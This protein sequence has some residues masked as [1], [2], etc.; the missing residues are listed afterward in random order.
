MKIAQMTALWLVLS[1][2]G[3][4][5]S[6]NAQCTNYVSV[7]SAQNPSCNYN[8][9][10]I[11]VD[12]LWEPGIIFQWSNGM[13]GS[14]ISNLSAGTYTVTMT[15][16]GCSYTTSQTLVSSGD[17]NVEI[18]DYCDTTS[19]GNVSTTLYAQTNGVQ[20]YTYLWSDG[21][22]DDFLQNATAASYSV[23]AT[24]AN[25][26]T[27][28]ASFTAPTAPAIS[29]NI[30]QPTCGANGAVSVSPSPAFPANSNF[31]WYKQNPIGYWQ[32]IG[33]TS[34]PDITGIGYGTYRLDVEY[35]NSCPYQYIISVGDAN[36]TYASFQAT[37]P[38]CPNSNGSITAT[39]HNFSG[40]VTYQWSTGATGA[41]I[42]NLAADYYSV[43]ISDGVCTVT[44][45]ILLTAIM[46]T[47][48]ATANIT[49]PTC[50]N[51][52]SLNLTISG[53]VAP[54]NTY[55]YKDG[56]YIGN[57]EDLSNIGAGSYRVS[58]SSNWVCFAHDDFTFVV[59]DANSQYVT[60]QT[61]PENCPDNDG[62]ATATPVNMSGTISYLWNNGQTGATA[63]GLNTGN[64]TVT[65]SSSNG[66][67]V[68]AA[69]F[70]NHQINTA[71]ATAN[72]TQPTCGSNGSLDLVVSGG[73]APYTYQ[74]S[75][76]N[77]NGGFV[78]IGN[79]QDLTNIGVG[80]YRVI[81]YN[82]SN[83]SGSST[84]YF[85]VGNGASAHLEYTIINETCPQD[86]GAIF[87]VPVGFVNTVSY[88][89]SNGST[90]SNLTNLNSGTYSVTVTDGV[91]S[92]ND[93]VYVG[94]TIPQPDITAVMTP[95]N[96]TGANGGLDIT[97]I[98]GVGPYSFQWSKYNNGVYNNIASTEDISN[99]TGGYY[100]VVVSNSNVCAASSTFY[101]D[102]TAPSVALYDQEENCQQQDGSITATA[103]DFT[104]TVSYLWSNGATTPQINNLSH[105]F[106]KV[107][108]SDASCTI[109]E[110]ITL[111]QQACIYIQGRV[112][113]HS[114]TG[115]CSGGYAIAGVPVRLMPNN[116]VTYTNWAGYYSF[117]L[118]FA[119]NYTVEV[120]T[121]Y[122]HYS[123]DC[124][125]GNSYALSPAAAGVYSGNDFYL[126]STHAHDVSV[127]V[128]HWGGA[129]IGNMYYD[130]ITIRNKGANVENDL[131]QYTF[132]SD[133]SYLYT[134]LP[135]NVS[136]NNQTG[137]VIDYDYTDLNPGEVR[138]LTIAH[139]VSPSAILGDVYNN[140]ASIEPLASDAAPTDNSDCDYVTVVGPYDPNVKTVYPHHGGDEVA[141]GGIY[142]DEELLTYT[143][144]FQNV[145]TEPAVNV[146]LRDTLHALLDPLSIDDIRS[147][148]DYVFNVK[149]GNKIEVLFENINLPDTASDME[150][151]HGYVAFSIK[152][153]SGLPVGTSIT[154]R[155]GIYFDFN[156]PVITNTVVSTIIDTVSSVHVVKQ[157]MDLQVMPNPF[158]QQINIQYDLTES[159]AVSM[160]L[161]NALGEV[162]SEMAQNTYQTAGV[163][164]QQMDTQRLP[165]G[166]YFLHLHTNQGTAVRRIVKQ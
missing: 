139:A 49:Q 103:Y 85:L 65:V 16:G 166:V 55:W 107:T 126:T 80:Y 119:G 24:D 26:C 42:S 163:H 156:E 22:T 29:T 63:T 148:H 81:I 99:Q 164:Q 100:R 71:T 145:G 19:N 113:E 138:T 132:D 28:T 7:Y 122:S 93:D 67:T 115:T 52:G 106:Y 88:L 64:Y 59:G 160:F 79:T 46:P 134:S 48:T 37:Q 44:E 40:V 8:N 98:D 69:G 25:G 38:T 111:G 118:Y 157:N 155:A 89:W 20:P 62:T 41:T 149:D 120:V 5:S 90:S 82:N 91:C 51:N 128:H 73:T 1:I 124:P 23:T 35:S 135:S 152:R 68:T 39:P 56:A 13:Y 60:V 112:F 159:G 102:I 36:S 21:S 32:N 96:C 136:F 92:F 147:S 4:V 144:H 94:L 130:Y 53:G 143:L 146:I 61:T 158:D 33:Y 87:A 121:P 18:A 86:N 72:I 27:G 83:C 125:V 34:T 129:L 165:S 78:N 104:G 15:V 116:I 3:G 17:L 105:G 31:I 57:T 114:V 70:V 84:H 101:L 6:L 14:N 142:P 150:G 47:I 54:Y 12:Y 30:T 153:Q 50:G 141:G 58:V 151:S 108:V 140:C 43:T 66:C 123:V 76:Q 2:I 97:V 77:T 117:P 9:G 162:V 95:A 10:S 11:G 74:W 133:M 45:D 137:S 131:L 154:N 127:T 109:T 161:Y 110:S 75:K